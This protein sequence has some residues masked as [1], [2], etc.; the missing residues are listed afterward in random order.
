MT[1]VSKPIENGLPSDKPTK[2]QTFKRRFNVFLFY[3]G[4]SW[5]FIRLGRFFTD[6]VGNFSTMS[7]GYRLGLGIFLSFCAVTLYFWLKNGELVGE[8]T[9]PHQ[10]MI[11]YYGVLV[12]VVLIASAI[13]LFL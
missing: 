12:L 3:F 13:L 10:K 6:E 11:S 8:V 7:T 1:V 2:R 4:S 9:K 5:L